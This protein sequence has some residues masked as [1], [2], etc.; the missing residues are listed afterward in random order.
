MDLYKIRVLQEMP[1]PKRLLKEVP[2]V[3]RLAGGTKG[4]SIQSWIPSILISAY[5]K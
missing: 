3:A 1:K 5:V 2:W 4:K